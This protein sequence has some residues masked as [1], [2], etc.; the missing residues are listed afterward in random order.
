MT[1]CRCVVQAEQIAPETKAAL[2]TRLEEFSQREFSDSISISWLE[3]PV[4]NGFSGGK[5]STASVV[6]LA[7]P[8]ALEQSRRKELLDQICEIWTSETRCGLDECV[9]VLSDPQ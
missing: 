2:R 6:S 9:A 5:P 4:N 1:N 8:V 7:S 3:V